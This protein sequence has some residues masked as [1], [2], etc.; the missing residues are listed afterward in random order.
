M[1]DN[2]TH[3]TTVVAVVGQSHSGKTSLVESLAFVTGKIKRKGTVEQGS[4]ISDTMVES[5][6]NRTS[7]ESST[8]S[9][10]YKNR[11]FTFIDCPGAIDF[12]QDTRS[13]LSVAD[14][15][16]VVCEPELAKLTSLSPVLNH[17]YQK[18]IP[19]MIFVNKIADSRNKFG[20]IFTVLQGFSEKTLAVRELPIKEKGEV[21]GFVDLVTEQGFHF[22]KGKASLI[23]IPKEMAEE[24]RIARNE[25]LETLAD[26]DDHILEQIIEENQVDSQ[27]I[28]E[29]LRKDLNEDL[30]VPVFVGN[31]LEDHGVRHLLEALY[32]EAPDID[33]LLHRRGITNQSKL[34]IQVFKTSYLEHIGKVSFG[35]VL[36]GNLAIGDQL[37]QQSLSRIDQFDGSTR[38]S[39]SLAPTGYV[40]ALSK[41]PELSTGDL[42]SENQKFQAVDW[43]VADQP[44]YAVSISAKKATDELK[45]S[46]ALRKLVEE[47]NSLQVVIHQETNET[48]LCGQGELQIKVALQKLARRHKIELSQK[49]PEV[50]FREALCQAITV[51]ARHKKQNGGHGQFGDVEFQIKPLERGEGIRFQEKITGGAIPKN[52][53]SAIENGVRKSLKKGPLGYPVV[54]IEVILIDGSYHKVDSSDYAFEAAA[55]QG[56]HKALTE[57]E[58]KLLEPIFEV[59]I[60]IPDEALAATQ[61]IIGSRKGQLLGFNNKEGWKNWSIVDAYLPRS[62]MEGLVAEL[63]SI[64]Q[65]V[66]FFTEKF[67]YLQEVH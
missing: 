13:A 48:K 54:D 25:F 67:S 46:E 23:A 51:K 42:L 50:E 65:G 11:A 4:T 28:E 58:T 9:I 14:I 27:T 20:E 61:K 43:P 29:S 38:E 63:R 40:I 59:K 37:N 35:R 7:V 15:A 12:S 22:E 26:F 30:I 41:F 1:Y 2:N 34:L 52:Y 17:L 31:A 60:S 39:L 53:F 6:L 36:I 10:N 57:G 32:Q 64:S 56:I 21:V 8:V 16:V 44:T 5:K 55:V 66:G 49:Q 3:K 62:G 47:D 19:H 24:E 45:L 33:I 18:Q